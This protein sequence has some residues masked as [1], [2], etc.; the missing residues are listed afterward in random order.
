LDRS[1]V[2]IFPK[3][4]RGTDLGFGLALPLFKP[5]VSKNRTVFLDSDFHP[6]PKVS[7]AAAYPTHDGNAH[8][9]PLSRIKIGNLKSNNW[10]DFEK[11]QGRI[12]GR[13]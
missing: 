2:E 5:D 12:F 4:D 3:Q 11:A 7:G 9:S 10:S 8:I 1:E 13:F 6:L